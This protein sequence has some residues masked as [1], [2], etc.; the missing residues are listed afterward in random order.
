MKKSQNIM[1]EQV[2]IPGGSPIRIKWNDYPHFTYPWHFHSEFEIVLVL[3]SFGVRFVADTLEK[4]TEGDL[5]LVGSQVPHYWKN[6]DVFHQGNPDLKVNAV[7]IQFSSDF[8]DRS[9]LNYPELSHI[10]DLLNRAGQ[11]IYFLPAFSEAVREPIKNL[12]QKESFERFMGLLRILDAMARTK[13]YRLLASPGFKQNPPNVN[14][15][16]LNKILNYL[17][18][19]YTQKISLPELSRIF[20]MNASSFS[21][22]FKEKT[23]KTLV[24]YINEL[25][26]KYACRL[27]QNNQGTIS[28]ICFECGFN[29][30]SNFNRFFREIMKLS[31]KEYVQQFR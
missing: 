30:I 26:I 1:H 14:D 20:G 27:L 4:F 8:M 24:Q 16:R 21:R 25:R 10:R 11:G 19:N 13:Q 6:D 31:P 5:V 17:N 2:L 9:I 28:S 7:V 12:I 3:K 15:Q 23:G 18:L 22:Y 29:N